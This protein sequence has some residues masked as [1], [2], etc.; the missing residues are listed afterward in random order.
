MYKRLSKSMLSITVLAISSSILVACGGGGGGDDSDNNPG[1]DNNASFNGATTQAQLTQTNSPDI[2]ES[3][4]STGTAGADSAGIVGVTTI[5][6]RTTLPAHA[7]NRI[8]KTL[9]TERINTAT[10]GS[11]PGIVETDNF[12]CEDG[13]NGTITLDINETTGEAT[14]T[15]ELNNCVQFGETTDGK[16]SFTSTV[17]LGT[18][19]FNSAITFTFTNFNTKAA[20]DVDITMNGSFSCSASQQDTMFAFSCTENF[21]VRDNITGEVFRTEELTVTTTEGNGGFTTEIDG[22]FYH[23]DHGFVE[24]VTVDEF[25]TGDEDLWPSRGVIRLEGSNGSTA[26]IRFTGSANYTLEVDEDGD[27]TP[28]TVTQESWPS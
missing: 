16:M 8:F 14:G 17:D 3:T 21:D 25:F 9:I 13:G 12:Q 11:L 23:P 18:S 2:A 7:L 26:T 22:K 10:S 28:D 27:G 24:I 5:G 4:L 19:D 1:S 15:L 6:N 20:G